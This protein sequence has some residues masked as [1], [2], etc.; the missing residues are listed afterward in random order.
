MLLCYYVVDFV[1]GTLIHSKALSKDYPMQSTMNQAALFFALYNYSGSIYHTHVNKG[2]KYFQTTYERFVFEPISDKQWLIVIITS[3]TM[4]VDYAR[5]VIRQIEYFK[6][7]IR[8]ALETVRAG[9]SCFATEFTTCT[10]KFKTCF[11]MQ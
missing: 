6:G 5:S 9:V 1:G 8:E 7:A 3:A 2:L 11:E 10:P 4:D